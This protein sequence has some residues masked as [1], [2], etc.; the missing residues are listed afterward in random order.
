M[1]RSIRPVAIRLGLLLV[2]AACLALQAQ[3]A[4]LGPSD[5][6][7]TSKRKGHQDVEEMR[8]QWSRIFGWVSIGERL[9]SLWQ[10]WF[11]DLIQFTCLRALCLEIASWV[12]VYTPSVILVHSLKL[13]FFLTHSS[14]PLSVSSTRI[15]CSSQ[16]MVWQSS[17]STSGSREIS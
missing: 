8:E 2:C 17:L 16:Q 11:A 9:A 13:P 14:S 7:T 15:T 3:S 12:I 10:N 6:L 5:E 4:S 1:S